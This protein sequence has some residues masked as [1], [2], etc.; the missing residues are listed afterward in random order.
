[1]RCVESNGLQVRVVD[2]PTGRVLF[3][4]SQ[5]KLYRKYAADRAASVK[6]ITAA[7][8]KAAAAAGGGGK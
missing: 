4:A 8:A 1:M 6:D 2:A 3:A 7:V 5:K